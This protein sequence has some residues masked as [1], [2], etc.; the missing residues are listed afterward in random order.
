MV[1]LLPW[2]WMVLR[3][4]LLIAQLLKKILRFVLWNPKI[5]FRVRIFPRLLSIFSGKN[6]F[7]NT[8]FLKSDF[9]CKVEPYFQ[10]FRQIQS[11]NYFHST[12]L[13]SIYSRW[14]VLYSNWLLVQTVMEYKGVGARLHSFLMSALHADERSI[15]HLGRINTE[16]TTTP[17]LYENGLAPE[18]IWFFGK[19]NPLSL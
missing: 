2:W 12:L 1:T 7:H 15:S 19:K 9:T 4:K 16:N 11:G 13:Q 5:R 10:G 18:S 3:A 6:F 14:S 17:I 8:Y